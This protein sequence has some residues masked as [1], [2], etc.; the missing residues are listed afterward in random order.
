MIVPS[1]A[2][3]SSQRR[4]VNRTL[5]LLVDLERFD[6]VGGW[7]QQSRWWPE[8]GQRP[9]VRRDI[10]A[11]LAAKTC[12][13]PVLLSAR[14]RRLNAADQTHLV[15]SS[16]LSPHVTNSSRAHAR[17]GYPGEHAQGL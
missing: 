10:S 16:D 12:L 1:S 11:S 15:G 6:R 2:Q 13:E 8:I 7:G 14:S 3:P 4:P 9:L 5:V 17:C